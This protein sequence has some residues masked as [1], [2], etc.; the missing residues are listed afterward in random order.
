MLPRT[1]CLQLVRRSA[2]SQ[3]PV[4]G[5]SEVAGE[6]SG[7]TPAVRI[8]SCGLYAASP[9]GH[10]GITEQTPDVRS[11]VPGYGQNSS[12]DRGRSQAPGCPDRLL[13]HS[14]Y[15]G[16]DTHDPS[17]SALCRAGWWNLT[18]RQPLGGLPSA[19]L[20]TRACALEP[21]SPTLPSLYRAGL[22][23]WKAALSRP[24]T[25]LVRP[26]K[27]RPLPGSAAKNQ[28]G[29]LCQATVRW[30]GKGI[31]LSGPVHPPGRHLQP[32]AP[33][34]A[35][36]SSHVR[37]Q[38]LQRRTTAEAHDVV[39]RRVSAALFAA[40][41]TGGLPADSPL[42]SFQQPAPCRQPGPLPRTPRCFGPCCTATTG[43]LRALP[44][45]HRTG[46]VAMPAVQQRSDAADRRSLGECRNRRMGQLMNNAI[47]YAS[48]GPGF[49]VAQVCAEVCP[50]PVL[51]VRGVSLSIRRC[52]FLG[53]PHCKTH[54]PALLS[55]LPS[56][57]SRLS[58]PCRD[59][60]KHI[61]CGVL[62][63]LSTTEF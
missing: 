11:V 52:G 2:L 43:L 34:T 32:P 46:S 29:S 33:A 62:Q 18:G 21:V 4:P 45:T 12:I 41:T 63:R 1:E 58:L 22:H 20:V 47:N 39:G 26:S 50:D 15:L 49:P 57:L 16:T 37:L 14:A 25:A 27:L 40:C 54:P 59:L 28:M 30:A 53:F 61:A 44:A 17:A 31:R 13:L 9:T 35:R 51:A 56:I 5:P 24:A 10:S 48:A 23:G 42:W 7:P 38:G 6:A 60:P 3:V 8:F 36:R 55:C 19:V